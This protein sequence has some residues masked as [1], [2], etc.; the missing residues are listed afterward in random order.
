MGLT[1]SGYVLEPVRLGSSNAP[2]TYTPDVAITNQGAFDAAYPSTEANPRTEYH[3]FVLTDGKLHDAKFC[4]TKNE[5]ISRFGYDGRF[6]RFRTLPGGAPTVVGTLLATANTDRLKVTAPVSS[7]V[8][9]FPFRVSVGSGTG[10]SFT[11]ILVDDD[12]DFTTPTAGTVELSMATGNLNWSP[13]DLTSFANQTV[14]FQQQQFFSTEQSSA[15]LGV[16]DDVLLLNPI[17]ATGQVPL[18]RIGFGEFLTPI[19]TV[20]FSVDPLAGTVEWEAG[21]GRLKF[22]AGDVAANAGRSVYYEGVCFGFGLT[23]SSTAIGTVASPGVVA[24]DESQGLYFRVPGVVQFP[25]TVYVDTFTNPLIAKRGQVEVRRSDGQVQFALSDQIAYGA[26]T[27]FAVTPD[28][29]IERGMVL[30]LF[31]A[32]IDLAGN[33]PTIKDASAFYEATDAVLADPLIGSPFF[34]LPAV[35]VDTRAITARITQ[36]TGTATLDPLPRLDVPS[37]PVGFG[38]IIDY[39]GKTVQL[40]RRRAN[41][42]KQGS[43]RAAYS[44][45]QLPDVLLFESNLVLELEA[46]PGSNTFVP[47]V[48]NEEVLINRDAGLATLVSTEGRLITSGEGA[49]FTGDTL[50][51][52]TQNFAASAQPGDLLIITGGPAEG[53]YTV[54]AVGTSTLTTGVVGATASDVAY[55]IRRGAEVLADRYFQ[56]VPPLDPNTRV[57][58]LVSLGASTNSPRMAVDL[59]ATSRFRFGKAGVPF[60]AVPVANDAGFTAPATLATG[61]V[62]FSQDTGNLNFSTADLG[63]VIFWAKTQRIGLDFQVNAVLGFIEF[64]DRMLESEEVFLTYAV[65]NANDEKE[66]V[67]ERGTFLVRKE[68]TQAHPTPTSTLFFNPLGREVASTPSPQAFRGGR[69]QVTGRQVTFDTTAS[70]ATFTAATEVTDALPS[71]PTI[72]PSERVYIDYFTYEAIGGEKS[73]NVL[74]PPF[75]GV[76]IVIIEGEDFFTISGDRT[77]EFLPLRLLRVANEE[78]YLLS[79]STYDAGTDATTVTL[80]APQTFRSDFRNPSLDVS[81]GA[82]RTASTFLVPGYFTT[83]LTNFETVSRGSKTIRFFGDVSRIYQPGIVVH[84]SDGGSVYEFNLVDGSIYDAETGRTVVTLSANGLRQ[85]SPGSVTLKRSVR[86]IL[87]S[88]SSAVS[89]Q[90]SPELSLP[91]TVFRRVE[92]EV[93]RLLVQPDDFKIDAAGGVSFSEPLAPN[94][95]LALLYTGSTLVEDGRDFRATYSH[96]VVPTESNGFANQVL[97]LDYTTYS[98]DS[99]Y[100]RVETI[101]NFR[102]EL[103]EKYGDEAK[104]SIPTAGPRLEN[105]SQP[106]LFEQGRESLF[107]AERHLA[108]EDYVAR[109]VLKWFNDGINYAEDALQS[110][111]G[112]V[113]GD[114][115]GRFR[116]DGLTT[117]PLRTSFADVTNQIDDQMKVFQ[118][119]VSITMPGFGVSFEGSYQPVYKASKF[120]RFFPTKRTLA[121]VPADPTG[122]ETGDTIAALGFGSLSNVKQVR[123]RQPWAVVTEAAP[124]GSTVL[125]VDT[126]GEEEVLLRPK[127]DATTFTHRVGIL[128]QDGT[129]LVSPALPAQIA[130]Q[131]STSLTF[132]A[133]IPV[134][135]PV[136]ATVFQVA[137]DPLAPAAPPRPYHIKAFRVGLD[138]DVNLEE[139]ELTH[140]EPF[141]PYDG[142]IAGF[143]AELEITNPQTGEPLDVSVGI[144]N[145]GTEP[146]RF[147]ALDGDTRDDDR[148][149][150]FPILNP[151]STSE[152]G[153]GVGAIQQE[154][155]IVE[156]GGTLRTATTAPY[157]GVGSLSL[158]NTRITLD[159]GT[160]P[161]PVP[162][163]HDLVRIIS[164]LNAGQS[165]RRVTA[166]NGTTYIEVAD[167]WPSVDSAF[168]FTVAVSAPLT[169]GVA[170]LGSISPA[171][172]LTDVSQNF[173]AANVRV[174]DTVVITNGTNL[175]IRRQVTAIV[176][177]TSLDVEAFPTTQA[178]VNSRVENPLS[179]FG[180]T[181]S[182]TDVLNDTLATELVVL[183]SG[184]PPATVYNQ[185]DGIEQFLNNFLTDVVVGTTGQTTATGTTLTDGAQDFSDVTPS[186]FVFVRSGPNA[187]AYQVATVTSSTTLEATTAFPDTTAVTTYR[188]VDSGGLLLQTLQ[189][190]QGIL[191]D[192]DQAVVDTTAFKTLLTTAV[193]VLGDAGAFATGLLTASLDTREAQ[194]TARLTQVTDPATGA[195]VLLSSALSSGNRFYDRRFVWI[196]ARINLERGILSKKDRALVNRQKTEKEILKQLTKLLSL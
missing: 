123:R 120:S 18:I 131:T 54:D 26:D 103:A 166:T 140:V 21:T 87:P 93:G 1:I 77:G 75:V 128:A 20:A 165:F 13:S 150:R 89:T 34:S 57:E 171:T 5:V 65:I 58:R 178:G 55:E 110:M 79:G 119:P 134:A 154:Q 115:D 104:E 94:E 22:N 83:E 69:P 106:K 167:A 71:G 196:D 40:A 132:T 189:D 43:V 155:T 72:G 148:N 126:T 105:A 38:Y 17:P 179:T 97:K 193:P 81:S 51:D 108:N 37:P 195:I 111:D 60:D 56:E 142:S 109:A 162:K 139:G 141:P 176:S 15:N 78:V 42:L 44:S 191:A 125:T 146:D 84:W 174:G 175:G 152:V 172:R 68:L 164:G 157:L 31:R 92:G 130:S 122:L 32:P 3:V 151:S 100:W 153:A 35:P 10:A 182:I 29:E 183:D 181:G 156:S 46:S 180:G 147:P 192:I 63:K 73:L 48:V 102:A 53:V 194:I 16:I 99:Y 170:G 135:V 149:R 137:T 47:L 96:A 187:G 14:R 28:L 67:R 8:S 64:T 50:S 188:I 136:G 52:A 41:V 158:G 62:E 118:G 88:P 12:I 161:A 76:T 23:V 112:R 6:Q 121:T 80:V 45:V 39:E 185:R 184:A 25:E 95:E 86:P 129:V 144:S 116:F 127:W 101:S 133:A 19:E 113:V 159:S 70:T 85:Y 30:R 74:R 11:A 138:L 114:H 163:V 160:F 9:A 143:P 33:D 190:M 124:A 117:N 145:P 98:P 82:T 91:F 59:L 186:H 177:S 7:D 169:V 49:S 27:V 2:V 4:W 61:V 66:I 168:S 107:F 24:V 90:R 36:G 173:I